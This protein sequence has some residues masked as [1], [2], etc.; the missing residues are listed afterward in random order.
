MCHGAI[1]NKMIINTK[2]AK[3]FAYLSWCFP[4]FFIEITILGPY[5]SFIDSEVKPRSCIL[6]NNKVTS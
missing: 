1:I 6:K 2:K 4:N 3:H 5:C